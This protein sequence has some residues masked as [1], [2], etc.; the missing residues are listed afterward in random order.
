MEPL[1]GTGKG[2]GTRVRQN[3]ENSTKK[4]LR[5]RRGSSEIG[6]QAAGIEY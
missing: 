3:A 6:R 1:R 4:E 5:L 2:G